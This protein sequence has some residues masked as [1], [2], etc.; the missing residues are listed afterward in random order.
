MHFISRFLLL[1]AACAATSLAQAAPKMSGSYRYTF[2]ASG[3]NVTI[4]IDRIANTSAQNATGNL[5]VK[6]WALDA[7]YAGG[8]LTGHQVAAFPL[9]GLAGGRQYSNLAK[10][11]AYQPPAHSRAYYMCVTVSEYRNGGY[12]IVDWG[13][14]P[15]TKVL[16][17]VKLFTMDGPWSWKSSYEGGT[18][19]ISIAKITHTRPGNTGSL[20]IELWASPN[21]WNGG[22]MPGAFRIATL[23]KPA[24]QHGNMYSNIQN[25]AKFTPP[26]DG[27]YYVSVLL[28]EF[29]QA[30]KVVSFIAGQNV[31]NFRKP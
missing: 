5:M 7:P 2:D 24:L 1:A 31:V 29:D 15:N 9:E 3:R 30:Y 11:V 16:G 17:P 14:L 21:H 26:P 25:T 8:T 12:G 4:A 10:T 19:D 23:D 13:N 27:Q 20:R 18:V 22:P 28:Y 6:L